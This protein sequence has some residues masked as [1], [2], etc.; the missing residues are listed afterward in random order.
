M[1]PVAATKLTKGKIGFLRGPSSSDLT[2]QFNPT[3]VERSRRAIYAPNQA[4]YADFPNATGS[5]T[6]AMLWVRNE[7]EGVSLELYFREYGAKDVEDEL[8]K[9]DDFMKPDPNTGKP[10]D[11]F[12]SLGF[13]SDRVRI[14][15]KA[16]R[17]TLRTPDLRVQ[18]ARVQLML[19]SLKSRSR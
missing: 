14:L 9:L 15:S 4:V 1:I 5:A 18:E 17:E 7:A 10:Q 3:P 16:V 2:F 12:L 8:K 19:T 11:L 13:R 6:P